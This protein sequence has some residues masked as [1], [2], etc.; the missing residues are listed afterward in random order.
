MAKRIGKNTIELENRPRILS[1]AAIVGKIEGEGPLG[2]EFDEIVEDALF[3]KE[4][5]EQAESELQSKT[6]RLALEKAKVSKED[7]DMIFAGDLLNQCIASSF[8]I[9][10]LSIPFFGLYGACS[11]ITLSLAAASVFVDC[12]AADIAVSETS[13]HFCSAEKQ[14]RYPLEYGSQRPPT[15]QRTA[16]ACGA[17]VLKRDCKSPIFIKSV[18]PGKIM[19]LGITDA[20]N[21]GAAMAPAAADTIANFLSDTSSSPDDYDLILTGDLGEVGTKLLREIMQR[22]YSIDISKVHNDCGLLLFDREKQDVHAGGSG[23]GCCASVLSS[24]ILTR[25]KNGELKKVLV[26]AT[27]ALMSTISS[28][29]GESIPSISH[30][31]LL[32]REEKN[33]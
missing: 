13:S 25:M 9:R 1:S 32:C 8:G 3:G 30:A 6:V 15:A 16:T 21:M 28:N 17:F 31:V 14:F 5:W 27:G 29:E 23:C 2:Q 11:T 4:N 33:E 22:E 24:H 7:V 18:T 20:N 10:D 26:A 19:D 12:G